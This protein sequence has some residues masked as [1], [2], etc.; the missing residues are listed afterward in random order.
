MAREGGLLGW[1]WRT[2]E[3]NHRDR[4]NLL[5]HFIAV[6]LFIAGALAT[7]RS[8]VA[9]QWVAAAISAATFVFAFALQAVGHRREAEAPVPFDGPSDFVARVFA[10]QFI[11]FPRFIL[12]GGWLRQLARVEHNRGPHG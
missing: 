1:Q 8:A 10:E 3:R 11:T 12:S 2:Y 9:G 4:A 6:P 5:L 7:V